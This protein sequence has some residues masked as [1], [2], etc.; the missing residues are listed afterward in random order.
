MHLRGQRG[1]MPQER[2]LPL[3][4]LTSLLLALLVVACSSPDP[5][6]TAAPTPT[7]T[8]TP[9]PDPQAHPT[10]TATPK[11]TSTPVPPTATSTPTATPTP[12]P[13]ATPTPTATAT[14]TPSPTPTP[15][16]TPLPTDTPAPTPTPEPLDAFYEKYLDAG[17]IPIVASSRVPDAAL[18]RARDIID[19]LLAN[20]PD[21]RATIAGESRRVTVV[22]DSEVITDIPEFR[23]L[24]EKYPGTDWDQRI[25]SG[26][27]GNQQDKTTAIWAQNLLCG[28]GDAHPDEDVFVHE[29]AHTILRMGVEP[30]SGGQDFRNRLNAAYKEAL[31]AGLW[32]STYAATNPDEYWAEGVQSWFGLND[33]PD[34]SH[35][36]INTRSELEV[37]DPTLSGLIREVFGDTAVTSSC[38]LTKDINLFSIQGRVVG[39]D[40]QPLEGIGLWAWQGVRENSG[41]GRTGPDGTF[42]LRVPDGS[43]TLDVYADFDAG[44]TFVGWL[45]PGG[46]TTLREHAVHVEVNDTDVDDILIKL[47]DELDH[48]PFIEHC[49]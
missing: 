4:R 47:P 48:L 16:V 31:S 25:K 9:A 36:N 15:T 32:E 3:L 29:F 37:Y 34:Q 21:L 26:L 17:G 38:H 44:C 2:E 42:V 6:P 1:R 45:G 7:V 43:F 13:T 46:F 41:S 39:P 27:A 14:P 12:E 49:S 18:V 28:N 19:E 5:T 20:R 33:P 8:I 23:D 40:D 24:Y 30:Q 11:P 22:A 35:N 10:P